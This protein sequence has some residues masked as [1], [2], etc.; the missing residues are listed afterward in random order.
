[1]V[2]TA[3]LILTTS[4]PNFYMREVHAQETQ[5]LKITTSRPVPGEAVTTNA[6]QE[7]T[8]KWYIKDQLVSESKQYMPDEDALEQWIT[9]RAYVGDEQIG[10]DRLYFSRLPVIYINIDDSEPITSKESYL[11]ADMYVQ[12]NRQYDMQYDGRTQIRLRGNISTSFEQKPYKIKLGQST[13]MF[14]FGKNKHWVL[15]SNYV[16]Q[17]SMRNKISAELAEKLGVASMK[18]TPVDVDS[19]VAYWLT[20]EIMGNNDAQEKSRFAYKD[21][22]GKLVYGPVWDFDW[23]GGSFTVGDYAREWTVSEG[24]IWNT[25]IDDPYFQVKALDKYWH[26][27]EY[28]QSIVEDGGVL[29][30]SYQQLKEAGA[31]NDRRYPEDSFWGMMRRNFDTD[32][33]MYKTYFKERLAWLDEQFASYQSINTSLRLV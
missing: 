24:S 22:N 28:L 9:A 21:T 10:E 2:L 29:D 15:I 5:V 31:A 18:A 17:C 1:M 14:G 32:F 13:D 27:R 33:Q 25:F 4:I 26:V 23:G 16:D 8:V 12:G 19:M 30:Q 3:V 11:S 20:Q 6:S 7:M